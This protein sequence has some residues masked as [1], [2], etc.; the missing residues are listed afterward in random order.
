MGVLTRRDI[1]TAFLGLPAAL[2]GC[3]SSAPPLPPGALVGTSVGIGH[4]L[5]GRE[6]FGEPARWQRTGVVIVGGGV[7]G[8][9]AAW[10]FLRAGFRDFVLLELEPEPGGTS[11][12]GTSPVASYPWGAHY[13][14]APLSDNHLL[15]LLLSEMG[16]IEGLDRD[17]QPIVA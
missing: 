9:A 12:S 5:R 3:S 14:P 17:G 1:L 8:L 11:R 13:I 16:I 10:R 7:A 15:V 6:H 2:A 4:R